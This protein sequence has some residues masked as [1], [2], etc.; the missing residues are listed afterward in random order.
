MSED[1][2]DRTNTNRHTVIARDFNILL[3]TNIRSSRYRIRKERAQM[4]FTNW[5]YYTRY[6]AA[7]STDTGIHTSYWH[8]EHLSEEIAS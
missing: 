4:N 3:F 6:K 1:Q 7:Y 8:E 2:I 5:T